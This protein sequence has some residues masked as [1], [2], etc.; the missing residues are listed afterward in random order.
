[1]PRRHDAGVVLPVKGRRAKVDELDA[2]VAHSPYVSLGGWA[3]LGVPVRG[4][5]QDVLRLQVRVGQVALVQELNT[6]SS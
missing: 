4:H 2:G 3:E 1:M 6:G 5:E